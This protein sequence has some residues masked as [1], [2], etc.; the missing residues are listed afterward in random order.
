MVRRDI[1][2]ESYESATILMSGR[3][4]TRIPVA[5]GSFDCKECQEGG[6][7][8]RPATI[9]AQQQQNLRL[10]ISDHSNRIYQSHQSMYDAVGTIR[11]TK[12]GAREQLSC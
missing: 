11:R 10:T 9:E 2:K 4:R 6:R 8:L 5:D 3:G 1:V 7:I 12:S